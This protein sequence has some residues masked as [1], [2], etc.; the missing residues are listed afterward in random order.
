M[1]ER[2]RKKEKKKE[3]ERET[4][5]KRKRYCG[6]KSHKGV[7]VVV[8]CVKSLPVTSAFHMDVRLS[9]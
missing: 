8:Q 6:L 5:R 4:K 1:R 7:G 2:E 3:R 9:P